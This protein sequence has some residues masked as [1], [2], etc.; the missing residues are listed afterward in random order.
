MLP[1]L[2]EDRLT[3]ILDHL[4]KGFVA[5]VP[6]ELSAEFESSEAIRADQV[7]Y[8]SKHFPLCM[9]ALHINLQKEHHLKHQGRL[10]YGLFLK[11]RLLQRFLNF[12]EQTISPAST[13]RWSPNRRSPS[14][15]EKGL[16]R[17]RQ[18]RRRQVR[19]RI[20]LQ[21]QTLLWSRRSTT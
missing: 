7:D 15:L 1:R 5:G 9:R 18:G 12:S 13:G 2:D 3:P 19:Q 16:S 11:V 20:C 10:Q 14:I 17:I 4:S 8:L 21:Y 6:S